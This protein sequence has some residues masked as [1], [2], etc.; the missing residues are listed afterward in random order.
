MAQNKPI[1]LDLGCGTGM[2]TAHLA[3]DN[4][5]CAIL[6]IDRSAARLSRATTDEA[7]NVLLLRADCVDFCR[8]ALEKNWPVKQLY[9]FYPNP[10]PKYTDITKRWHGHPIFPTL[11]ALSQHIEVRSNWP[12]YLKEFALAAKTLKPVTTE[13]TEIKTTANEAISLFEKK[14]IAMQTPIYRLILKQD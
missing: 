3:R 5:D 8:L 7:D 1:I 4:P 12:L 10:Y 9:F 13:L 2:S 14:Y 6:G 11:L